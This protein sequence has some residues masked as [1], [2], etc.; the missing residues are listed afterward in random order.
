MNKV[1]KQKN[2]IKLYQRE[3][4]LRASIDKLTHEIKNPLSVCNGYLEMIEKNDQKKNKKYLDVVKE[5]IRRTLR[6]INDF[7]FFIPL[8]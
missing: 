5:E 1:E 8:L 6:V 2:D 4:M 7:S 3:K